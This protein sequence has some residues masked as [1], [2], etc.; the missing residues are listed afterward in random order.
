MPRYKKTSQHLKGV[1]ADFWME[2]VYKN[3]KRKKISDDE[4]AD[5]L[6]KTYVAKHGIG[7][8][9][10]RTHYDTRTNGP[11]RWDNR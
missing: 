3:G 9:K 4:I 2:L 5:E 7:R 11:A 6:E 8:Y 10:G 1:A